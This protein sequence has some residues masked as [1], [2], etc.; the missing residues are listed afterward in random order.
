MVRDITTGNRGYKFRNLSNCM[1][2]C[3]TLDVEDKGKNLEIQKHSFFVSPPLR[4][5]CAIYFLLDQ[6]ISTTTL[7]KSWKYLPF[8]LLNLM[9][10]KLKISSGTNW[11]VISLK[12]KKKSNFHLSTD[13]TWSQKIPWIHIASR[14]CMVHKLLFD[15]PVQIL[16]PETEGRDEAKFF[17]I[18]N[19]QVMWKSDKI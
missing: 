5:I 10:V 18:S 19:Y 8:N 1:I 3:Y 9:L 13:G 11:K 2:S 14:Y 7:L 15:S 6:I 17:L 16:K 4:S 12:K